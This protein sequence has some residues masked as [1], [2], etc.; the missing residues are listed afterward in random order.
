MHAGD[1]T[2]RLAPAAAIAASLGTLGAGIRWNTFAAGGSDSHCYLAQAGMLASGRVSLEHPLAARLPWPDALATLVPAG[3][4]PS[5]TGATSSVPLCPPGLSLTM[6]VAERIGGERAVFMAVPVLGALAVLLSYAA[7]SILD[8]GATGA[9]AAIV[10][11]ASPIF[12][13]QIVQPMSDVPVTTWWLAAVLLAL[14]RTPAAAA[15]AGVA[16]SIGLLT[17]PNLAPLG[18]IVAGAVAMARDQ[19]ASTGPHPGRPTGPRSPRVAW[20]GLAWFAAGLAPG[21]VVLG[22]L[23]HAMYGAP[24]RAGYGDPSALFAFGH[25]PTNLARYG[26]WL[27][28]THSPLV[29]LAVLAP[30]VVAPRAFRPHTVSPRRTALVG[31]AVVAIVLAIYAFYLPFEDWWYLRFLLPALPWVVALAAAVMMAVLRRL[32]PG[33]RAPALGALCALLVAGGVRTAAARQAFSL[34]SLEQHFV[35]AGKY[36]AGHL[37]VD[38]VVLTRNHRGS[39]PYYSGR[40]TVGWD[41]LDPASLEVFVEHF[42]SRS[43]PSVLIIDADEEPMFRERFSSHSDLGGLD[44]P[45]RAEIRTPTRVHV[46]HLADRARFMAGERIATERVWPTGR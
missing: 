27:V 8:G 5:P 17:R 26:R 30:F 42:R 43:Q 46:Y 24:W 44:W 28:E 7:G 32:S 15:G 23:Q 13:Y 39:V 25:V 4:I 20:R 3:F 37:E 10:F 40:L 21:L 11:A 35:E 41:S 33:W 36:A 31:L 22:W 34:Q 19:P 9:V 16:A 2:R 18:I 45:P 14:R 6:A 1:L 12:L 38:T 29:L